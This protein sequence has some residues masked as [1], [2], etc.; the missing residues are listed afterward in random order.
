MPNSET[1]D[2]DERFS[3]ILDEITTILCKYSKHIPIIAG[4][5]NAQITNHSKRELMLADF[6]EHNELVLSYA[7]PQLPTF[8]HPV[9]FNKD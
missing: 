4:D 5:F 2:A 9:C 3:D 7:F 6:T 1:A 8:V